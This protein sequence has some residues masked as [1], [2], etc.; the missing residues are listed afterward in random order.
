L[1]GAA[2]V[3]ASERRTRALIRL[4]LPTFERPASAIS[5]VPSLGK[6]R[7]VAALMTKSAA[8]FSG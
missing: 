4:D 5:G 6:S 2:L 1:P 3:R 7:A 8:I